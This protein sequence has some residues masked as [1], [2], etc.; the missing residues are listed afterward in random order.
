[1]MDLEQGLFEYF[2]KIGLQIPA[3][4]P[5]KMEGIP[6]F[7]LEMYQFR[8]V[9]INSR[10]C[11][12]C[13]FNTDDQPKPTPGML[14]KH[15]DIISKQNKAVVI[16]IY[17]LIS[18]HNRKRLIENGISFIVPGTQL[19]IPNLA[20]DLREYFRPNRQKKEVLSP[21]AQLT[22][23]YIL[24]H[25]KSESLTPAG[26][27]DETRYSRM[28][29]TRSINELNA[30]ELCEVSK[31]GK[32]RNVYFTKDRQQLW[33]QALPYL[34][35]PIVDE[36]WTFALPKLNDIHF[37]YSGLT[38]LSEFTMLASPKKE[39]FAV[40]KSLWQTAI[41]NAPKMDTGYPEEANYK[42]ELWMY[43]PAMLS[44][45][46][47]VDA[48]SLFLTLRDSHDERIQGALE[49]LLKEHKW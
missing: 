11:L 27:A 46:D 4:G 31:S 3:L 6:F 12:F 19:F 1:M 43:N 16:F 21:A 9:T 30:L 49:K 22:L 26:L 14:Q 5:A 38:A 20:M 47:Y 2:H 48:H 13:F 24:N 45:S 7:L 33:K 10:L 17:P 39:N 18:S 23:F 32:T 28:T 8:Q 41:K 25:K 37:K 15:L 42:I 40:D 35:S 44:N 34:R 36:I 29:M